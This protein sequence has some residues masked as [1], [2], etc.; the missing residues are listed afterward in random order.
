MQQ[1]IAA[2]G[3]GKVGQQGLGVGDAAGGQDRGLARAVCLV[4]LGFGAEN[5]SVAVRV[6]TSVGTFCT[7]NDRQ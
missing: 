3:H 2:E 5:D 1:L 6:Q 7:G 4:L